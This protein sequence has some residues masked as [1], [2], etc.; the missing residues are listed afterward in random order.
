MINCPFTNNDSHFNFSSAHTKSLFTSPISTIIT[1]ST[2]NSNTQSKKPKKP[3][4][5]QRQHMSKKLNN[6]PSKPNKPIPPKN[7]DAP[8]PWMPK[9]QHK[10]RKANSSPQWFKPQKPKNSKKSSKVRTSSKQKPDLLRVALDDIMSKRSGDGSKP[11]HPLLQHL[12]EASTSNPWEPTSTCPHSYEELPNGDCQR[13]PP[14]SMWSQINIIPHGAGIAGWVIFT[15][16]SIHLLVAVV[17][18]A[19]WVTRALWVWFR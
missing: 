11:L 1:M 6:K 18:A 8:R 16:L 13:M 5:A 3:N 2:I 9:P 17:R 14:A 12:H 10:V 15:C 4:T 19:F 7:A